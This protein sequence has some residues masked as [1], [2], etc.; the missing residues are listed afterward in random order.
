MGVASLLFDADFIPH[1]YFADTKHTMHDYI[2]GRVGKCKGMTPES[3][4]ATATNAETREKL[5]QKIKG[6]A[7]E[8]S[9]SRANVG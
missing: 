9:F 3:S 5:E 8:S 6:K 7:P 4:F 1:F 2:H